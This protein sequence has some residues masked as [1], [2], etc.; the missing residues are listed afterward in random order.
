M[1][2]DEFGRQGFTRDDDGFE[3]AQA[4]AAEGARGVEQDAV[5]GGHTQQLG[6]LVALDE[7]DQPLRVADFVRGGD[8]QVAAR[9]E[10]APEPGHR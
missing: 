9:G 5:E 3:G 6:D 8:D 1:A 7:F 4:L 10:G 2:V